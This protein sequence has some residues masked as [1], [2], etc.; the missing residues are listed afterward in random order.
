[1]YKDSSIVLTYKT[2]RQDRTGPLLVLDTPCFTSACLL[3]FS[4][5]CKSHTLFSTTYD[6]LLKLQLHHTT[7]ERALI[8]FLFK[9][10]KIVLLSLDICLLYIIS[11]F[12][13]NMFGY[14]GK[15]TICYGLRD[16]TIA[17]KGQ[18]WCYW[19]LG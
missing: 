13:N 4:F 5:Y 9:I 1:M 18:E 16:P 17:F 15:F 7:R 12:L 10:P 2:S 14:S 19:T 3:V 8:L 6:A 11:T